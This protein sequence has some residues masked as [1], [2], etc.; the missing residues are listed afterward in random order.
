MTAG[1]RLSLLLKTLQTFERNCLDVDLIERWI[2][3]FDRAAD[4]ELRQVANRYPHFQLTQSP[5]PGQAANLNWLYWESGLVTSEWILHWEDDWETVGRGH[6][7]REAFDIAESNHR[8]RN[9]VFRG[10]DGVTVIDGQLEYKVHVFWP[11]CGRDRMQRLDAEWYGYSLNPSLQHLPTIHLLGRYDEN[12][13]TRY[14]DRPQALTYR[15]THKLLRA[16][17]TKKYVE[18]IGG[19]TPAWNL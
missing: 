12:V 16:N 2:I 13:A 17:P 18:H 10:W 9:V 11:G 8:V 15:F 4:E 5:R 6:F 19:E 7:V 14:F 3:S 1:R